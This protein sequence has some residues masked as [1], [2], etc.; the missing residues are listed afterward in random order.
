[1]TV[2]VMPVARD[3]CEGDE[4]PECVARVDADVHSDC[5]EV[6]DAETLAVCVRDD[7]DE[8][9]IVAVCWTLNDTRGLT[10]PE[11]DTVVVFEFDVL[12][13]V[14]TVLVGVRDERGETDIELDLAGE[15]ESRGESEE[16]GE[17]ETD[18]VCVDTT[19]VFVGRRE[20]EREGDTVTEG[21][22]GVVLVE[23]LV[24]PFVGNAVEEGDFVDDVEVVIVSEMRADLLGEGLIV[25]VLD[26][27]GERDGVELTVGD[28]V[29]LRDLVE[30]GEVEGVFETDDDA[31]LLFVVKIVGDDVVEVVVVFVDVPVR[32]SEGDPVT[33]L[34]LRVDTDDVRELFMVSEARPDTEFVVE[35]VDVLEGRLD[36]VP[37]GVVEGLL[38]SFE[39]TED[40]TVVVPVLETEIE[41]VAV[42]EEVADCETDVEDVSVF[43]VRAEAVITGLA[44]TLFDGLFDLVAVLVAVIVFVDKAETEESRVAA[45]VALLNDERVEDGEATD[46]RL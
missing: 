33:D 44:E 34:V 25:G 43:E 6:T 42:R 27:L 30:S 15:S 32:D 31:V 45:P 28:L 2:F 24:L 46:E 37:V 14:V 21:V 5:F 8:P 16:V 36:S 18:D 20:P 7:E 4:V 35:T 19:S 23:V 10:L 29:V 38:D 40:V 13:E 11:P 39:V 3:D 12:L 17:C 9:V 22:P 1:M 26:S 41:P